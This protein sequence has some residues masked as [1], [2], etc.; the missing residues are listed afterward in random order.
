MDTFYNNYIDNF[1][2]LNL[3]Y[4]F[5]KNFMVYFNNTNEHVCLEISQFIFYYTDYF[6]IKNII[7][8]YPSFLP[9]INRIESY[10]IRFNAILYINNDLAIT[11][12]KTKLYDHVRNKCI[13][14]DYKT[15]I[16]TTFPQC[17]KYIIIDDNITEYNDG[18][19]YFIHVSN[20]QSDII[21]YKIHNKN[22]EIYVIGSSCKMFCTRFDKL[23]IN[24]MNTK[25]EN[26][27]K[28]Y[29]QKYVL[30]KKYNDNIMLYVCQ[31]R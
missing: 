8:L 4:D 16:S 22:I 25:L 15:Y 6:N 19:H 5:L 7:N 10:A 2:T 31:Y 26:I 29:K 3:D 1:I 11:N 13:I 27:V 14:V 12:Y 20:L 17:T 18:D 30:E 23:Y 21:D 24:L 28:I 9:I